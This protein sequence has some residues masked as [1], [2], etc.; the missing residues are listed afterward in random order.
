[1]DDEGWNKNNERKISKN[2]SLDNETLLK[3]KE[4]MDNY[5]REDFSNSISD[6]VFL[7]LSNLGYTDRKKA[8][9]RIKFKEMT[10]ATYFIN[11]PF[12]DPKI[13]IYKIIKTLS[14]RSLERNAHR[15]E[16]LLEAR[17]EGISNE[18][19]SQ[20]LDDLKN[21]REIYEPKKDYFKLTEYK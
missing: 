21:S 7:G 3:V 20:I 12:K 1:M 8:V 9:D 16:I 4:F 15:T 6:L 18:D 13:A 14:Q 10:P 11:L 19:I 5:G 2:F 17:V